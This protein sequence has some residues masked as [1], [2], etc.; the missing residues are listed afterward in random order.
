[1]SES[2]S[3]TTAQNLPDDIEKNK[4]IA[5]FSYILIFA[6]ILLISRRDS[7]FIKHHALQALY[8]GFF[9][10]I[11]A[12]LPWGLNYLNIL[13]VAGALM[14]FLEAQAGRY[15]KIPV[16]SDLIVRKITLES[17]FQK[18]KNFVFKIGNILRRIFTEG[19]GFAV[20]ETAEAI[21]KAR[22]IDALR[23]HSE[24][25][26]VRK[27]LEKTNEKLKVLETDLIALKSNT[28]SKQE[29]GIR[30]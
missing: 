13:I 14:G 27:V 18:L 29:L 26:E 24:V 21:E 6:P 17:T 7:D 9:F 25:E 19:P 30:K 16:V 10:V 15:Y 8:L 11:F 28:S 23:V 1:M 5:A 2:P 4:D 22:G 12:M 3:N 20:R